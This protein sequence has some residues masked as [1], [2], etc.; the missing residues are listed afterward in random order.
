MRVEPADCGPLTW[1]PALLSTAS[2]RVEWCFE[3]ETAGTD[4]VCSYTVH[5]KDRLVLRI[6]ESVRHI[7]TVSQGRWRQLA[8][9]YNDSGVGEEVQL[10][11]VESVCAALPG[12][13]AHVEKMI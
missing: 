3:D 6:V 12:W 13:V 9:A 8:G 5:T 2:E 10:E 1:D 4:T 11:Y 7:A